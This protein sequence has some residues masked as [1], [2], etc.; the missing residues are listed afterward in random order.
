MF[1]LSDDVSLKK[2]RNKYFRIVYVL[3]NEIFLSNL[4]KMEWISFLG[5]VVISIIRE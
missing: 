5:T 3:S 1:M 4:I 2:T